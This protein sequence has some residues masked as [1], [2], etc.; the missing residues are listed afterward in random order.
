[1][2]ALIVG[3]GIGSLYQ[4]VLSELNWETVTVDRVKP[5][6]FNDVKTALDKNSYFDAVFVCT[7]N[8]THESIAYAVAKKSKMVFIEKPGL[9]DSY[10]WQV[11]HK[12][13]PNTRFMMVKNNQYRSEIYN[14]KQ[15][16]IASDEIA[17]NWINYDR[18]PNPGSWFTNRA[19]SFGGVS[20]D[21]MP[22]LLS[23]VTCFFPSAFADSRLLRYDKKQNWTLKDL[24]S[25]DYGSVNAFGSYNVD[26]YAQMILMVNNIK[27]ILTADWR[28]LD[29]TDISIEFRKQDRDNIRYNLDLCPEQAYTTMIK[30]ALENYHDS[31]WWEKNLQQDIWIHELTN[32][33]SENFTH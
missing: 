26:D 14:F 6:D 5:A 12:V 1:M 33:N 32:E 9:E 4:K 3:L 28:S 11:M 29:K 30:T 23:Y 24:S 19:E 17:I 31:A 16:A 13:F 21:L 27:F 22:H 15:L 20:K 7:P 25:T 2:K 10:R 8:Y 18:V